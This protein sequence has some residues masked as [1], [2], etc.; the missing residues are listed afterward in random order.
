[1]T[2]DIATFRINPDGD[3]DGADDRWELTNGFDPLNAADATA[4]TDGDGFRNVDE[5]QL[6]TDPRSASD[7]LKLE[8]SAADSN[9]VR[10]RFPGK[11]GKSYGLFRRA[12][13]GDP[14]SEVSRFTATENSMVELADANPPADAAFYQIQLLPNP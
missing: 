7:V 10:F 8:L 4:D 5:F 12:Q 6:G 14:W 3:S 13:L 2:S 1:M 9:G 11:A